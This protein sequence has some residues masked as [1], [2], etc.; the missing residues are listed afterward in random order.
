V[1]GGENEAERVEKRASG[2]GAVSET[3]EE[4]EE[5]RAGDCGKER[6]DDKKSNKL[7]ERG[8]AISLWFK[9]AIQK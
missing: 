3:F 8:A 6:N 9:G 5:S 4:R 7:L 2:S 1:S